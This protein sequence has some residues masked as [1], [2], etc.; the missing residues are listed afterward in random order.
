MNLV[1]LLHH[2]LK[3]GLKARGA[4][5]DWPQH[6]PWV[7]FNIRTAPKTD[8]NISAAEMLYRTKL[9]L[10]AQPPAHQEPPLAVVERLRAGRAIPTRTQ[11]LPTPAVIR[12][13][14][15][16]AELVYVMRG[17]KGDPLAQT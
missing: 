2:N 15:A 11:H 17:D 13:H 9:T 4:T 8:S 6:L 1:H 5:A 7:L 10:P 12:P 14:L 16:R 3:E